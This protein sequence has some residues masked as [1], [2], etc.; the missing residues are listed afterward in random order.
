MTPFTTDVDELF[1]EWN[2][3]DSP[4]CAVAIIQRGQIIH[5][6]GYGM[7]DL[8]HAIPISANSV[9]DIASISKQFTALNVTLLTR[10]KKLSLD[11]EIQ[12]H[13]PGIRRYKYPITIRHLI[14]H[15]SGLRDYTT[16][17]ELAGLPFQNEYPDE[18]II[19]LIARQKELNFRPGDEHLYSNSGYFL[20][21]E[22]VKR[23]SGMSL[24]AFADENIF[25]PL[26]MKNSHFH[27]DFREIVKNRAVG[28]SP[29]RNGGF[30]IDMSFFDGVGDGGVYTTIEDLCS[31]DANFYHNIIGGYGQALIEEVTTPGRL[32]SGEAL[33]YAFGLAASSYRGLEIIEHGGSW[34]G[35]RAQM[36][37]F[38]AQRFSVICLANLSSVNPTRLTKRIADIYLADAFTEPEEKILPAEQQGVALATTELADRTG[39][40]R[41]VKHGDIWELTVREGKLMAEAFG[42][43]FQ[44]APTNLGRY[45]SVDTPFDIS[46]EF[47]RQ[48]SRSSRK[49][50]V[51]IE[52]GQ[53][54]ILEKVDLVSFDDDQTAEYAGD[55]TSNELKVKWTV[56]LEDGGLILCRKQ[57]PR[58][59][60][61]PISRDLFKDAHASFE[62]IR[63]AQNQVTGFNLRAGWVRKLH[64]S[65]L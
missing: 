29:N 64:F 36:M 7:A 30:R 2:R 11:D 49:I 41:D 40:Y 9:F 50:Y 25:R 17:M 42:L 28:Y 26:A 38:P 56:L 31:W 52:D 46:L 23:V 65:K 47:E 3:P 33:A 59:T 27:D 1:S 48:G 57:L 35:Y 44:L 10:Q 51:Q 8:E 16:L 20:L 18:E 19:N 5:S 4:G 37:R 39:F 15:V 14:H 12:K 34:M 32:N 55:Y 61:K 24:R 53:V 45:R 43:N 13:L 22:I 58:E 21:G 63:N 54:D 6:R 62:F 60:L